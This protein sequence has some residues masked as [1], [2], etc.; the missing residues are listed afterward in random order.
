MRAGG[1]QD[2]LAVV[3][4]KNRITPSGFMPVR[5]RESHSDGAVGGKIA[6]RDLSLEF[7]LGH[8]RQRG[9][10][11]HGGKTTQHLET[12]L[13]GC[14]CDKPRKSTKCEMKSYADWKSAPRSVSVGV[15][16]ALL[17]TFLS[18]LL[19]TNAAGAISNVVEKATGVSVNVTQVNDPVEREYLKLLEMDDAA[20]AEVDRWIK[21]NNEFQRQAAGVDAITLN[22]RIDKRVAP[23]K[24]AYEDFLQ[25][26]PNHAKA[27]L[28]YGSFL[29]DIQEEEA[30]Q[31]QWEK[32][33]EADP[34]NPA[35]WNNLANYYGHNGPVTNAFRYYAKAIELDPT[36]ST[37]YFNLATTVYLFRRD[38]TNFYQISE[39]QVFEKAMA[40]YRKALE[41]DP[42]NFVLATDY[43]Q[44]YYAFD[45]KLTGDPEQDRKIKEKRFADAMAAWQQAFKLAG[46]DVERQGVLVHYAR[47]QINADRFD[48]ARK[49]LDAVTNDMFKVTK[50]NLLKKLENRKKAAGK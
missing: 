39:E 43:A 18:A 7:V 4:V 24:K 8:S 42:G 13:A 38:A 21:E 17:G 28:A 50:G 48:E 37:Y 16:T 23:V 14:S 15:V 33:R 25:R 27:R 6:G 12:I 32:A 22:A 47:L 2:V 44:S 1:S 3:N 11:K 41:L 35:A 31:L 9:Q 40:L 36:Q 45:P 29:N 5:L 46:D 19:V 26:N 10:Q 49:N 30:A 20:Q 34:R